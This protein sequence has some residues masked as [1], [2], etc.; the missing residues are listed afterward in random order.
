MLGAGLAATVPSTPAWA[1]TPPAGALQD[2]DGREQAVRLVRQANQKLERGYYKEALALFRQAYDVYPSPKLLFNLAQ[3]L[4]VLARPLQALEHYE[5]F[6][7]QMDERSAK[8]RWSVAHERIFELE[9]KIASVRLQVNTPGATVVADG[10]SMGRT[11]LP[12]A[13]R[14]A[15]GAHTVVVSKPGY[16]EVVVNL[17]LSA[18]QNA[19]ERVEML[20]EEEEASTR[21]AV[22]QVKASLVRQQEEARERRLALRKGLQIGGWTSFGLGLAGGALAAVFGLLSESEAAEVESPEPSQGWAGEIADHY[23]RAETFRTAAYWA[24]GISGGLTVVGAAVAGIG[25]GLSVPEA[26]AAEQ[27]PDRESAIRVD[28]T[29]GTAATGLVLRGRF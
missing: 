2:S 9:G 26:G 15:P 21:H 4:E 3:T 7:E 12:E 28:V 13:L 8:G 10:A 18:G 14:F 16:G 22:R 23:D 27:G 29:F 19:T 20:T 6:V 5:R 17:Q 25:Y 11:P 1:Q 24:A